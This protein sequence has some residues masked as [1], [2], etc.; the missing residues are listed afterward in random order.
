M[1]PDFVLNRTQYPTQVLCLDR[2]L[3]SHPIKPRQAVFAQQFA[4]GCGGIIM[5]AYEE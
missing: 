5:S 1:K 4:K 3:E 2:K